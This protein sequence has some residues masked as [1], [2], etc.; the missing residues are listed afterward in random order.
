[1]TRQSAVASCVGT[2]AALTVIVLSG[3][4]YPDPQAIRGKLAW[5]PVQLD[6]ARSVLV[7]Q[8]RIAGCDRPEPPSVVED[9][10]QV[11][12]TLTVMRPAEPCS[13][14]PVLLR[15]TIRLRTSLGSR[16]LIDGADNRPRTEEHRP[17]ERLLSRVRAA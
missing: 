13:K 16:L 15:Q 1:M 3:G 9:T 14:P 17:A 8:T 2:A 11:S 4:L 5:H 7:V 6:A 10:D 12:I